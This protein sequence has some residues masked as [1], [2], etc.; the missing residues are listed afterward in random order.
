MDFIKSGFITYALTL[1]LNA[2]W[3]FKPFRKWFR[4]KAVEVGAESFYAKDANG[5]P[6]LEDNNGTQEVTGY[7]FISCAMCTGVWIAA[8]TCL[9]KRGLRHTLAAYG[10]SYFLKTQERP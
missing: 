2:S 10:V 6:V 1:L 3:I 4:K 8:L 7:D 9:R 5:D